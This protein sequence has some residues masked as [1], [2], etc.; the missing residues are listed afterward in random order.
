MSVDAAPE[1]GDV[2]RVILRA[3]A[4]AVRDTR[5]AALADEDDGVHRH[6]TAVRRLRSVLAAFASPLDPAAAGRLRV[7]F[8]EWGGRLGVVRDAEVRASSAAAALDDAGIED[9]GI[10]RRLVDDERSEYRRLHAR[11]GE[12]ATGTRLA[13]ADAL[14]REVVETPALVGADDPAS[15]VLRRILRHQTRRVRRAAQRLDGT[16][17]G[18][19]AVRK[20][21][22]R[23]RYVA[24]AIASASEP[25]D[26][27]L[28]ELAAAGEWVHDLLGDHR[29]LLLF[30]DGVERE[31]ARAARAG[32]PV[33]PYDALADGARLEAAARLEAL[34]GALERIR[35]AGKAL[36]RG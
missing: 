28:T 35:T 8:A 30:A 26:D 20:A 25:A 31:R 23:L 18:L 5:D 4:D 12:L 21:A 6:R 14:L 11:L 10:R 19:H 22:R 3:A 32:E 2:V 7:L 24:E 1:T 9:A 33:A 29:D 16:L 27:L 34:D 13:E 17:E 15:A 36:R